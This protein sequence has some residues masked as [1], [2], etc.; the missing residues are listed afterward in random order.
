MLAAIY[1][2]NWDTTD[3]VDLKVMT[4][5]RMA[6]PNN[7]YQLPKIVSSGKFKGEDTYERRE[8]IDVFPLVVVHEEAKKVKEAAEPTEV[9]KAFNAA[10]TNPGTEDVPLEADAKTI[11]AVEAGLADADAN[12]PE[13]DL[14]EPKTDA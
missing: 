4:E 2:V 1:G 13:W 7:V 5:N 11:E 3:Y 14:S 12:D 9:E 8:N 10:P 6:S